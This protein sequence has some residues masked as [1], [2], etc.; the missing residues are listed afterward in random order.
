MIED[1]RS[2]AQS[3]AKYHPSGCAGLA[4]NQLGYNKR[5]FVIK[6]KKG[7]RVF[8]N[9]TFTPCG[10]LSPAVEGCLSVPSRQVS[11]KRH[12]K[13]YAKSNGG[14]R[15]LLIGW[16]SRAFQHELDHLNGIHI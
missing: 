10:P 9:P 15:I 8:V 14:K 4:A 3:F 1:I 11:V 7:F 6:T 16:E 5:I 2:C 13:I 12:T